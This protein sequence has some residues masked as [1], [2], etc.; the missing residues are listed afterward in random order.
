ME[1][2]TLVIFSSDNGA[3]TNFVYQRDTFRHYS[4]L[5]FKGGKR[6]IYEGRQSVSYL[7]RWPKIIQPV[8]TTYWFAKP[9]C[10][11]YNSR[12]RRSTVSG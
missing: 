9:I 5:N 2:N 10:Y 8:S 4:S 7:M 1:N 12:Y 6:D 11:L 3:E